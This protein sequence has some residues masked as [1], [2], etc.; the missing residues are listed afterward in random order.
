MLGRKGQMQMLMPLCWA[1]PWEMGAEMF[2][3]CK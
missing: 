1:E 3:N 2:Y